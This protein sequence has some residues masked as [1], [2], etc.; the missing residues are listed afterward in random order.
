[1]LWLYS[2]GQLP[3]HIKFINCQTVACHQPSYYLPNGLLNLSGTA[4]LAR[5]V[6]QKE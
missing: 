2:H 6:L 4:L 5:K 1:M 3:K